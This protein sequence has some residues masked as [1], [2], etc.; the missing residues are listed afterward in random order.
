MDDS[1]SANAPNAVISTT[2]SRRSASPSSSTACSDDTDS[3]SSPTSDGGAATTAASG[4]TSTLDPVVGNVDLGPLAGCPFFTKADA[5]VF[6][7]RE[8]GDL[9]M[10]GSQ[11]E[12]DTILAVC[13]YNDTSGTPENGVSVSAKLVPGSGANLQGDLVDLE[14]NQL[15]GLPLETVDGL[16]VHPLVGYTKEDDIPA[17]TRMKCYEVLLQHYYPTERTILSTLPAAMRYA[18][19][20]EAIFHAIMR[21]NYGCTHFIVGRDHAG[22]GNYY[23]TYDAQK[24]FERYGAAE[25]GIEPMKFEHSFFCKKCTGMGTGKTCPHDKANHVFLSGTKVRDML[26]AGERPPV[27]FTR[28]EVAD[29]LIAAMRTA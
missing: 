19:P 29:V 14:Q 26:R 22:V 13:A 11:V 15:A 17:E 28:S 27:E 9:N 1:S 4:A 6:L 21:K 10:S 2:G 18:G 24:E 12:E 5:E 23:G 8:V 7:G 3:A 16:L 25:L 20:K